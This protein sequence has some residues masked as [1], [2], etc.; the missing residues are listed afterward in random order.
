MV[1]KVLCIAFLYFFFLPELCAQWEWQ[2]PLPQGNSLEQVTFVDNNY[3][4]MLTIAGTLMRTTDGGSNWIEHIIGKIWSQKIHFIDRLN[5]WCV[6]SGAPPFVMKTTDGGKNWYD[7]PIPEERNDG[8]YYNLWDV[9]FIDTFKGFFV[10][11]RG[12]IFHTSD[13]GQSWVKQFQNFLWRDLKSI[14]FLDSLKGF[15]VGYDELKRTDNGGDFWYEDSSVIFPLGADPRKIQFIDDLYGWI[16]SKQ[17]VFR[18][19]NRGDSWTEFVIDSNWSHDRRTRDMV[20]LNTSNGLMS[21]SSGLYQSTD[22]G[23]TW[24]NINPNNVVGSFHFYDLSEGWGCS[25]N[26][27][28]ST[29]DG[30][31]TWIT[32]YS[33]LTE[34]WLHGLDF[35]DEQNGWA[36][37][38]GG[39]IIHT[40]DGGDT[41][42]KQISNT[43]NQLRNVEF[44]DDDIGWIV[45]WGGVT[46]RTTNGG[47][48]WQK[49]ILDDDYYLETTS[50]VSPLEG[51]LVSRSAGFVLHTTDGGVSWINQTTP[52]LGRL[53]GVY[54]INSQYGWI[55][56]DR[57]E[58]YRTTNGGDSWALQEYDPDDAFGTIVFVDSLTG[59]ILS[60][61]GLLKTTNGGEFWDRKPPVM[62]FVYDIHFVDTLRGWASGLQGNFSYTTDGGESWI[63]NLYQTHRTC[64]AIDFI[65]EN[66]GWAVGDFG[67]ILHTTNGGISNVLSDNVDPQNVE[68]FILFQNYPNPFNPT[69]K[70]KFTVPNAG[71]ANFASRT[72][73]ILKVYDILGN[74]IAELVNKEKSAGSYEVDFNA[75]D[76]PSGVYFY[77]LQT[78]GFLQTRKMILIK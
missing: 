5:G 57:G 37:G 15:A 61:I 32:D 2:N 26:K 19:T 67:T 60:D 40:T 68:Y 30:G 38:Y 74:E 53:F 43:T 24:I 35:V 45:G 64:L 66:L 14:Y 56:S 4:W 52:H 55:A 12:A 50:F 31:L 1:K 76:L 65:N 36:V 70:I 62:E 48:L 58:V 25:G 77:Q 41:W 51:W 39:E 59:W 72:K 28:Y 13:G 10:D 18:T 11:S 23:Q 73:V 29:S 42:Q 9:F 7:L 63:Q 44:W 54:F 20:F 22:S 16:M 27:Q 8:S 33:S 46:L 71:D 3:G 17:T 78:A 34:S 6:G 21:S 75:S 69:T 47:N 49:L